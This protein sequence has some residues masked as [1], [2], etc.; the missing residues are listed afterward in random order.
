M[1]IAVVDYGMG[2]LRSVAK[3][4]EHVAPMTAVLRHSG[5]RRDRRGRPR[6]FPRPGRHARLHAL[7]AMQRACGG[8]VRDAAAKQ[9]VPRHVHRR[10]DVVRAERGGRYCPGSGCLP[11][12]CAAFAPRGWARPTGA[13][14]GAAHGLE[15]RCGRPV[16]HRYGAGSRRT[17]PFLLRAQLL[18][19]CRDDAALMAGDPIIRPRF[20]SAVA[21]IIFS[22]RS[23]I[24]RK[25]L[26]PGLSCSRTSCAGIPGQSAASAV[27]RSASLYSRAS[28]DP[29]PRTSSHAD[30]SRDR[31]EGRPVRAPASRATWTMPPC[32][33]K[34]R[35]RWRG[36][37][38][39]RARARLHL[40]D[41][42]GAFA[43][44]P[45]TRRR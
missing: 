12:R 2:N 42:N 19:S 3:A 38:S 30:H 28:V 39:R 13:V 35:P 22:R 31:P 41:L 27:P 40:V 21:G 34:I 16:R 1:H 6:G 9:A 23:S 32:F 10:A 33:P 37:G 25:A 29:R 7:S 5:S 26:P 44:K 11:A 18:S 17:T 36:T 43:G 24:P 8:A 4:L 14:E 20:T 15:P 45:A